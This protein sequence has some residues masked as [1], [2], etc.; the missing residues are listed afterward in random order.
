MGRDR[1]RLLDVIETLRIDT[2]GDLFGLL[3]SGLPE[4]FTT[5]DIFAASGRS[6]RLAMRAA[7]CLERSGTIGRLARRGR[8]AAY[9]CLQAI[10]DTQA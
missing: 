7:Y 8:F 1:W 4:V 5:A 3:P 9:G 6:K 2:P 10:A